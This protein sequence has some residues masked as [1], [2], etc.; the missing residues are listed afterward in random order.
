M[1]QT[2]KEQYVFGSILLLSNKLQ[3]LGDKIL[4]DLTLKQW[5]LLMM[6]SKMGLKDPSVKEISDFTGTSISAAHT[7]GVAA[8][9]LEWGIVRGNLSS[10]STIEIKKLMTRGARR[11]LDVEYPNRDWGYGILDVYNVFDSL[12]TGLAV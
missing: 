2:E 8:L 4:T 10:M 12:R 3:S 11:Q 7:A 6:I 9:L 5:F 1:N